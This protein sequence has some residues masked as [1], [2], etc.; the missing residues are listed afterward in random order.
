MSEDPCDRPD[1]GTRGGADA[2]TSGDPGPFEY[3]EDRPVEGSHEQD[4]ED[5]PDGAGADT[6]DVAADAFGD[7]DV[8]RGDPFEE[9][10]SAFERVDVDSVDPD[11]VWDRFTESAERTGDPTAATHG[12]EAVP[13]DAVTVPKGR[14]CQTCPHFTSP[15]DTSCTHEGTEILRF[16]GTD[17]VRVENCP[18]VGERRELGETFE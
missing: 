6:V 2:D 17:G 10:G 9:S 12:G 8:S 15:P 1:A 3:I 14:F 11:A 4:A 5:R 7:V 18:V 13:E 16:V